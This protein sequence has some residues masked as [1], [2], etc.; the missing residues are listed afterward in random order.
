MKSKTIL[1]VGVLVSAIWL[2]WAIDFNNTAWSRASQSQAI[3]EQCEQE[4]NTILR[5]LNANKT[6][7]VVFDND[8][9]PI[10]TARQIQN[11]I[12]VSNGSMTEALPLTQ[13]QSAV[14]RW[15]FKLRNAEMKM[16]QLISLLEAVSDKE[17]GLGIS[18]IQ[19]SKAGPSQ[20]SGG[21]EIWKTDV[22]FFF[23]NRSAQSRLH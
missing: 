17:K 23:L 7:L 22:S 12:P 1:M 16:T 2:L 6:G 10:Q 11:Q 20:E 5:L 13:K 21:T 8:T 9:I 3:L 19:M 15:S 14:N 4:K 18:Q